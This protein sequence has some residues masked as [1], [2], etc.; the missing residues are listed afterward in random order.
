MSKE[1]KEK[2]KGWWEKPDPLTNK[3]PIHKEV[4]SRKEF[5]KQG[6]TGATAIVP[7]AKTEDEENIVSL[8]FNIEEK[9]ISEFTKANEEYMEKNDIVIET[10]AEDN[11]ITV[12]I[13][14][15]N[16]EDFVD[17]LD[18]KGFELEDEEK[19][20]VD[21]IIEKDNAKTAKEDAEEFPGNTEDD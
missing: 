19:K 8:H 5:E 18:E 21:E 2:G 3:A 15:E 7:S 17:F 6:F 1:N 20:Q 12:K 10:E 14:V 16:V 4:A 9:D 13:P 11:D